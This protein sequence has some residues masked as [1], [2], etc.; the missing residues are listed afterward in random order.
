MSD[1][2]TNEQKLNFLH[3]ALCNGGLSELQY[4]GIELDYLATEYDKAK[5]DLK[6][7]GES[8]CYE[9]VLI[10][11]LNN[12]GELIFKDVECNDT[13]TNSITLQKVYD[14]VSKAPQNTLLDY[15]NENDD[16]ESG[17][18]LIQAILY[19]GEIIFG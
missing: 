2:L 15:L 13:Y 6:S 16:A 11:I 9:D 3:S 18:L 1:I 4:S 14:N 19:D 7:K 8:P 5:K 10:Q 12:G 17:Y